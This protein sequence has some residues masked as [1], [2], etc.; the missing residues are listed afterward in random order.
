MAWGPSSR[1][2]LATVVPFGTIR[3]ASREQRSRRPK[4][5][6][7]CLPRIGHGVVLLGLA[8]TTRP[9]ATDPGKEMPRCVPIHGAVL[10]RDA[11][12]W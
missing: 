3:T 1:E 9:E 7:F 8:E 10:R 5:I 2:A 12:Q 6:L 11:C 4:C